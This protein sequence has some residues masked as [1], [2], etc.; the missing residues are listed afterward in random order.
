MRFLDFIIV[1]AFLGFLF[2]GAYFLWAY[3]P[4]EE[5]NFE[6]YNAE[7]IANLPIKSSQ[8]YPNMRYTSNN[9][10]YLVDSDC[11]VKKQKDME[12][13]IAILE[14][15]TIL[16]FRESKFP[17]IVI[18]CS[19]LAPTAEQEDHFVAGEGGPSE[20]INSSTYPV[21]LSGQIALYRPEKCET[22]QVAL[23]E[24]LHALGF[25]HN[26]NK[27]S[28]MYHI[29][30]CEQTLDDEIIDE[31]NSLYSIPSQPDLLI[32][33]IKA[34]KTG[35]Y[36]NFEI[37][38]TN[39]GLKDSSAFT[40]NVYS[41]DNSLIKEFE[42]GEIKIGAKRKLSVDNLQVPRTT[43]SITFKIEN[44]EEELSIGNNEVRISTTS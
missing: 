11:S 33:S 39:K 37:I 41:E 31:I 7:E 44:I 5:V 15:Q 27:E 9:I 24:M 40:L 14:S 28:I 34:N 20:V 29:T 18:T 13:A 21:I 42:I 30:N 19:N 25:D 2:T 22:P 43:K 16:N 8:F 35:R 26:S 4:S 10:D 6:E 36:L 17:Q 38:I 23:H 12:R 32:E 3:Y 1:I